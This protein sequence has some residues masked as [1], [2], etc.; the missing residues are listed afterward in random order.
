MQEQAMVREFP[1]G[2]AKYLLKDLYDIS[3]SNTDFIEKG[4]RVWRKIG[5]VAVGFYTANYTVPT[6]G[7]I[8]VP[9]NLVYV[10][11]VHTK[12]ETVH[13]VSDYLMY[14]V[15]NYSINSHFYAD[16]EVIANINIRNLNEPAIHHRGSFVPF[17]YVIQDGTKY[18]KFSTENANLNIVLFYR[19]I[20]VNEENLPLINTKEAEAIAAKLA[21]EDTMKKMFMKDP[22]AI[23][24]YPVIKGEAGRLMASAKIAEVLT[25]NEWDRVLKTLVRADRKTYSNSYKLIS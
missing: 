8:E 5:N 7:L 12:M 17:D 23:Q 21:E 24:M 19:G 25:Q 3:L 20:L 13:Y 18:L 4:K 14:N 11:S 9:C 15:D 2:Y 22:T 16:V 1:F 10:D 6:N